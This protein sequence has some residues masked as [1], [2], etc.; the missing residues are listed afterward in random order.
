MQIMLECHSLWSLPAAVEI[1][2]AVAPYDI[3]WIE[4]PIQMNGLASLAD[5]KRQTGARVTASETLATRQAGGATKAYFLF[6]ST[7]GILYLAVTL[8]SNVVI[9]IIERRAYVG[10]P[11]V[12]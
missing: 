9:R 1:A 5:F 2:R 8:L 12:G 11:D 3:Y 10:M 6:F 7:G 4:D